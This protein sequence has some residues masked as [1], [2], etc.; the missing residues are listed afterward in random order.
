MGSVPAFIMG[1]AP[2]IMGFVPCIT[3]MIK[4]TAEMCFDL[5]SQCTKYA[6]LV[7]SGICSRIWVRLPVELL[8]VTRPTMIMEI[9][10]ALAE[11]WIMEAKVTDLMCT[12]S[13]LSR[14][15]RC[16]MHHVCLRC[17]LP[18][19]PHARRFVEENDIERATI[20]PVTEVLNAIPKSR[21]ALITSNTWRFFYKNF[22][23]YLADMEEDL[24]EDLAV[25]GAGFYREA[26]VRQIATA[27]DLG[28]YALWTRTV[29]VFGAQIVV[30]KLVGNIAAVAAWQRDRCPLQV[31]VHMSGMSD[32]RQAYRVL[33]MKGLAHLGFMYRMRSLEVWSRAIVGSDEWQDDFR[34]FTE[35]S[36][37]F[38]ASGSEAG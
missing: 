14:G 32:F 19:R 11:G 20:G 36:E 9:H 23:E 21:L 7:T 26:G 4:V 5:V 38:S 17:M 15:Q 29:N 13:L 2:V 12:Q 3:A 22:L 10:T 6:M 24:I 28:M 25:L 18:T 30:F 16:G 27:G 1:S 37:E 33:A 31:N 8:P 34:T 35:V